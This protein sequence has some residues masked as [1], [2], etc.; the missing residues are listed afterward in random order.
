MKIALIQ[1]LDLYSPD[2]CLAFLYV[3]YLNG[4]VEGEKIQDQLLAIVRF[5][6]VH[7]TQKCV[8]VEVVERL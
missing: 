4:F 7:F 1:A 6:V 3:N 8:F 2:Q 5:N